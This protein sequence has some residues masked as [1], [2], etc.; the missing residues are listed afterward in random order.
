MGADATFLD[1]SRCNAHTFAWFSGFWDDECAPQH[2]EE[3]HKEAQEKDGDGDDE[4]AASL[5][6]APKLKAMHVAG[7]RDVLFLSDEL[8]VDEAEFESAQ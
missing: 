6:S 2:A 4:L 7:V 5:L 1:T 3:E 8:R